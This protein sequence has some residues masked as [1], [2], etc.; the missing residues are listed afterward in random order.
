MTTQPFPEAHF[1][2]Y[3]EELCVKPI[4]SSC[5][6]Q[7]CKKC[8]FIRERITKPTEEYAKLLGKA[9]PHKGIEIGKTNKGTDIGQ[10]I[11][12]RHLTAQY[13]TLGF[14][15]CKCEAGWRSGIVLDPF[16]GSGTTCLVAQKLGRNW[17]GI[18]LKKEYIAI[19][20]KRLEPFMAE[21]LN[22]WS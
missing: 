3:P 9:N 18:D 22:R 17:I 12:Q 15:K 2:V 13:K 14:T 8:G 20:K 1:A 5:P 19:A 10:E 6:K 21:K 4:K 7:I 16:V 11:C